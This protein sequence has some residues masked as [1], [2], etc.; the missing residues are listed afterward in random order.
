[1]YKVYRASSDDVQSVQSV[2]GRCIKRAERQAMMYKA[3]RASSDDV[4]SVQS[5]KGR[6]IKC[7]ERQAM[8]YKAYRASSD[9]VQS[10]QSV[11]GRCIKVYRAS[12]DDA[13]SARNVKTWSERECS[14]D[15]I[16]PRGQDK[17]KDKVSQLAYKNLKTDF[18]RRVATHPASSIEEDPEQL[19]EA[20]VA[21]GW[22]RKNGKK[23]TGK[24][25]N[26]VH[27]SKSQ[28]QITDH[29]SD[30]LS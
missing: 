13:R 7:A 17:G 10:V 14:S 1:M 23:A 3:Y 8:M 22:Y 30:A 11:K 6:C 21:R 19:E 9:D 15:R 26:E 16:A 20:G 12:R 18:V 5:V 25:D 2:K 29:I 28:G 4:Q 27:N 24:T